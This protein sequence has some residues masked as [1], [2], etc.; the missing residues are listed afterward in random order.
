[1]LNLLSYCFFLIHDYGISLIAHFYWFF[2]ILGYG[3][4]LLCPV[5]LNMRHKKTP[6]GFSACTVGAVNRFS[7][8][9]PYLS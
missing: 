3:I 1:M 5:F 4:S 8:R 7:L 2:L 6:L 9:R